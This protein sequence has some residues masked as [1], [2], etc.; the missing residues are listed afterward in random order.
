MLYDVI[1]KKKGVHDLSTIER[2]GDRLVEEAWRI[3][4]SDI[5]IV[6]KQEVATIQFRLDS[7]LFQKHTI[8]LETCEKLISHFKFLSGMDIGERRRPQNGALQVTN[9]GSA[10]NLRLSTLPTASQESLVIRILPDSSYHPLERLSLFP[11]T[12]K[13][14]FSLLKH[15]HGLIVFT[16]PTGSGKTTTLYSLLHETKKELNRNIITLEDPIEKQSED[17]LQVQVNE[18]AGITYA[19]G[20]K[21]ILRHDP[22]I[23]MVGEI[24]DAETAKIAIRAA[25]TGHSVRVIELCKK[26]RFND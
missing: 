8:T 10:I 25:L 13:K 5:H 21:A 17:A 23:I 3:N 4:A 19:L 20:L 11:Q 6:P 14:L 18:K 26:K 22:D 7:D 24:R 12:S 16:G 15:S 2:L 9:S 1:S